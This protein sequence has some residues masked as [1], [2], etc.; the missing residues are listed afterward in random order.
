MDQGVTVRQEIK[1]CILEAKGRQTEQLGPK[2]LLGPK[3]QG[4]RGSQGFSH[5]GGHG[6]PWKGQFQWSK[7]D[8]C[9]IEVRSRQKGE[10]KWKTTLFQE[11][12]LCRKGDKWKGQQTWAPVS[13]YDS[14]TDQNKLSTLP[15]ESSSHSRAHN[16][17]L[18][19]TA[20]EWKQDIHLS[21]CLWEPAPD[22]VQARPMWGGGMLK[23]NKPFIAT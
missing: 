16:L 7:E 18:H 15:N 22:S 14:S 23:E 10:E 11:G 6:G 19:S 8:E 5:V 20:K 21:F 2:L 17:D 12:L 4:L 9:R 13:P 3:R 1:Q